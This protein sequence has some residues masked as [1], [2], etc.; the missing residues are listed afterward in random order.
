[1]RPVSQV[2]A[3][4][5][6]WNQADPAHK[7]NGRPGAGCRIWVCFEVF[8]FKCVLVFFSPK[9]LKRARC[10]CSCSFSPWLQ[11]ARGNADVEPDC[12]GRLRAGWT[13]QRGD[14]SFLG[15]PVNMNSYQLPGIL[16]PTVGGL[17]VF[18]IGVHRVFPNC[19][20]LQW[21]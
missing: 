2:L 7:P 19:S 9:G 18:T 17:T 20:R 1:M 4:P 12:F 14:G 15:T 21:W 11:L 8:F 3:D 6:A 16:G 10:V 5:M 13:P